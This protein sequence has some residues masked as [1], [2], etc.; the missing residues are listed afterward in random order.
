MTLNRF[1]NPA[2]TQLTGHVIMAMQL[3]GYVLA[4]V[5]TNKIF[6]VVSKEKTKFS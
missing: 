6:I 3:A 1:F 5:A 2:F 4:K